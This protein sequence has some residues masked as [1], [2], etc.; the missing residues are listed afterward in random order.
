[1]DEDDEVRSAGWHDRHQLH[2][3]GDIRQHG[4]RWPSVED[5]PEPK[6][7]SSSKGNNFHFDMRICLLVQ[8]SKGRGHE[9]L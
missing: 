7:L 1:M 5:H 3:R 2:V 4:W 8:D 6:A 9:F